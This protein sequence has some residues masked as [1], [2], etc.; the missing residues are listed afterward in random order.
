[1][2][3]IYKVRITQTGDFSHLS[4]TIAILKIK[5][6]CRCICFYFKGSLLSFWLVPER[7]RGISMHFLTLFNGA[8]CFMGAFFVQTSHA[9][10][11]G[12]NM[13]ISGVP[14]QFSNTVDY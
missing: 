5:Q 6:S 1:M 7:I 10:T 14:E 12:K 13:P 3:K 2:G 9:G 4:S 11:Q 8:G